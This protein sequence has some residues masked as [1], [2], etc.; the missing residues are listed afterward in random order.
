LIRDI[1]DD[2]LAAIDVAARR[3]G[4]S[5]TEFL[6]RRLASFARSGPVAV[7]DLARFE[8]RFADLADPDLMRSAWE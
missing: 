3:M 5:R 6:R 7:E 1:P 8:T 2:V 4:L